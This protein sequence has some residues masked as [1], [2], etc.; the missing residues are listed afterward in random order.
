MRNRPQEQHSCASRI[1]CLRGYGAQPR[2]SQTELRPYQNPRKSEIQ[3]E[4]K[5]S[6]EKNKEKKKKKWKLKPFSDLF[7][8]ESEHICLRV[9][10][11]VRK[12]D[13]DIEKSDIGHYNLNRISENF[14]GRKSDPLNFGNE[15]QLPNF[16]AAVL[17]FSL[18]FLVLYLF[19]FFIII[20]FNIF[21][22][23]GRV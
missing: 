2:E 23:V 7:L 18:I 14:L 1:A 12:I 5:I 22:F 19:F 17:S 10:M 20:F 8:L 13:E 3:K 16:P 6:R 15:P 21:G 11:P 4:K 9:L